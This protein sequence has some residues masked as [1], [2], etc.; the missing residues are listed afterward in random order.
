LVRRLGGE[1]EVLAEKPKF[2]FCPSSTL[3]HIRRI[4]TGILSPFVIYRPL[5]FPCFLSL[6]RSISLCISSSI[7]LILCLL[8]RPPLLPPLIYLP[9][10]LFVR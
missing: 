8:Y 10:S 3:Q 4:M 2:T 9:L 5:S 1:V 7:S 6:S